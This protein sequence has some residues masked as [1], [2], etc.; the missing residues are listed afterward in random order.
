MSWTTTYSGATG[1]TWYWTVRKVAAGTGIGDW[2]DF[3]DNAW[4]ASNSTNAFGALSEDPAGSGLYEG[5][6]TDTFSTYTGLVQIGIWS[7]ND[8]TG[9]LRTEILEMVA[10]GMPLS[11]V[12]SILVV[13]DDKTWIAK[14]GSTANN[15]VLAEAS[16]TGYFAMDFS[17]V[18][19]PYTTIASI[20]S[21]T[22]DSGNGLTATTTAVSQDKKHVHFNTGTLTAALTYSMRV[23]AL[24]TDGQPLVST[25]TLKA[26]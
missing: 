24:A 5:A 2:W 1:N 7:A 14:S 21:V 19:S 18:L 20:T 12:S 16:Y 23:N 17:K 3:V 4:D 22:D 25:G 10:G 6:T 13:D 9:S 8:G 26:T 11:A 15:V